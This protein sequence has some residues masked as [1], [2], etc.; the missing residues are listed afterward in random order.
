MRWRVVGLVVPAVVVLGLAGVLLGAAEPGGSAS[1]GD[2]QRPAEMMAIEL[3]VEER[4]LMPMIASMFELAA[5]GDVDAAV[6]VFSEKSWSSNEQ[7]TQK[8]AGFFE[9]LKAAG[10]YLGIELVAVRRVSGSL[11]ELWTL[12]WYERTPILF[13]VRFYRRDGDWRVANFASSTDLDQ[14][15]EQAPLTFVSRYEAP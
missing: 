4:A 12:A 14:V 13:K 6:A 2:E 7:T 11:T 9:R 15:I 1:P 5:E 3:P 10:D 8:L